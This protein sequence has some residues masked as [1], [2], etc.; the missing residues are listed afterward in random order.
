VEINSGPVNCS[1]IASY[2]EPTPQM[3]TV[4]ENGGIIVETPGGP[5]ET[6]SSTEQPETPPKPEPPEDPWWAK[7][8]GLIGDILIGVNGGK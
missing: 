1:K 4:G 8:I 3:C 7:L 2:L 5:I 6:F